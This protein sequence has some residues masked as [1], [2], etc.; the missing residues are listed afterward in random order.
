MG[1]RPI[2]VAP[3]ASG[4]VNAITAMRYPATAAVSAPRRAN[5]RTQAPSTEPS[6]S[7]QTPS[8][9]PSS[10][11]EMTSGTSTRMQFE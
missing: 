7:S 9:S 4:I 2:L 1:G 5:V 8:A 6:A 11:S 3:K 10:L